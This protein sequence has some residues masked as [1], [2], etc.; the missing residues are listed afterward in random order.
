MPSGPSAARSIASNRRLGHRSGEGQRPV[1]RYERLFSYCYSSPLRNL[2]KELSSPSRHT[3][4]VSNSNLLVA[5]QAVVF[6]RTSENIVFPNQDQRVAPSP[7]TQ[8]ICSKRF[9]AAGNDAA[10]A[11]PSVPLLLRA[12]GELVVY[13]VLP[14]TRA[15]IPCSAPGE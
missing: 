3:A 13:V 1:C 11:C 8:P 4:P 14:Q 9:N 12:A 2:R 7:P 10:L 5:P 15:T 6:P